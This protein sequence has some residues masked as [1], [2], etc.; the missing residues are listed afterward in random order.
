MFAVLAAARKA[1]SGFGVPFTPRL[2]AD[3][4]IRVAAAVTGSACAAAG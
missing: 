4:I 3:G 2:F 1:L